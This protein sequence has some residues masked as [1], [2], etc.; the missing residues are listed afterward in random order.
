M[1]VAELIN[2]RIPELVTVADLEPG[3]VFES[4]GWQMPVVFIDALPN[5]EGHVMLRGRS[6]TPNREC[7]RDGTYAYRLAP[8]TQV[9]VLRAE[10]KP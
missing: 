7:E 6:L 5:G 10:V 1:S 2:G 3:D 4:F 9:T 8:D